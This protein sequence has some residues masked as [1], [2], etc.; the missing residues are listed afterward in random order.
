MDH[1]IHSQFPIRGFHREL[2][3]FEQNGVLPVYETAKDTERIVIIPWYGKSPEI[4]DKKI[5]SRLLMIFT[6]IRRRFTDPG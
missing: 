4:E 3:P 2:G 5:K 1:F 6:L